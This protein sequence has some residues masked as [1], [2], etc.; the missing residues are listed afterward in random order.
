MMF[1]YNSKGTAFNVFLTDAIEK[2]EKRL[3]EFYTSYEQGSTASNK[4]I[5]VVSGLIKDVVRRCSKR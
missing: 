2:H 4:I 1:R 3:S 5:E